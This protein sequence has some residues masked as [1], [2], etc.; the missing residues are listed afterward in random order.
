VRNHDDSE[1]P[2]K[3]YNASGLFRRVH[4]LASM[5]LSLIMDAVCYLGFCL[6]TSQP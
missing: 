4:Q 2:S 1:E 3:M 5:L 6:C